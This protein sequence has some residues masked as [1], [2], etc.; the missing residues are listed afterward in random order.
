MT[1]NTKAEFMTYVAMEMLQALV[2]LHGPSV[3]DV[4]VE[5]TKRMLGEQDG[6]EMYTDRC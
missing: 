2:D 3:A 4:F 6:V 1:A 5:A